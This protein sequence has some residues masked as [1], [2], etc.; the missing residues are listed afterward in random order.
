VI[1][2]RAPS[3]SDKASEANAMVN[4]ITS[5]NVRAALMSLLRI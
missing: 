1:R 5:K 2:M 3:P 4:A